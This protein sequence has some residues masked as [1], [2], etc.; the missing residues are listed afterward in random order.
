M[1]A[2]APISVSN[3]LNAVI[4]AGDRAGAD[5]G[6]GADARVADIGQVVDLGARLDRGLLD[7]AEIADLGL[8]AADRRRA[9]G[10]RRGRRRRRRRCWRPRYGEKAW[11]TAP[12]STVDARPEK[13]VRLD[14]HVRLDLR[15]VREEHRF[16]RDHGDAGEHH[17]GGACAAARCASISASSARLLQ[18]S[19]FS[20]LALRW[21]RPSAR[22]RGRSRRCR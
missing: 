12:P 17:L 9:A 21:P 3:L 5:I 6:A 20:K 10:A 7:L 13:D 22:P 11:M 16:R 1:K 14:Q 8:V 4:V 2:P 15:V 18:P 19:A